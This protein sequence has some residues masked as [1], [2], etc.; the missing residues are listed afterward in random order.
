MSAPY[1][2]NPLLRRTGTYPFQRLTEARNAAARLH[3]ERPLVDLGAGEPREPTPELIRRAMIEAVGAETV[4]AY[5][6]SVG[7]PELRTAV[8]TWIAG[9]YGVT[10]DPDRHVLPTLGSKELVFTLAQVLVDVPGGRDL[11]GVPQPAYPV[12]ERGAR[13]AGADVLELPLRADAGFLPDLE[14]ITSDQWSR[15]ALLWV[16]YPNNPT[17][18]VA[19]RDWYRAAADRCRE[20]GVVLASD[21]AYSELWFTGDAPDSALQVGTDGDDLTGVLTVNTLSKRSSM[22]GYRSGFVAGDA[23]LIAAL[24]AFRP[25]VGVAPQRFV[26]HAAVAAWG[27]EAHVDAVR[28]RYREKLAVLQPGLDALGLQ[29]A[30]GPASFFRWL[31]LPED[32]ASAPWARE[33][34]AAPPTAHLLEIL[35]DRKPPGGTAGPGS[36]AYAA[37]LLHAGVVAAP[38]AFFGPAGEGYVRVALVPTMVD[39][40]EAA[41]RLQA[42]AA[43]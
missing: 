20:H 30:G 27:D 43:R 16:N 40:A 32:W 1:S 18:A 21:E 9:R 13:F 7:I 29:N 36:A 15:L 38:G 41:R 3:P 12:Y 33:A 37:A 34:L 6:Q 31:A 2:R 10:L 42:L 26:Q 11:V 5:P 28:E 23:D 14:A 19:S 25:S 8:A 22:P 17:A 35:T 39:C 24:K 4:S